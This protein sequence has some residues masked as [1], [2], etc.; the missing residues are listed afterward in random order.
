MRATRGHADRHG[1]ARVSIVQACAR[2]PYA[3]VHF[4]SSLKAWLCLLKSPFL[5]QRLMLPRIVDTLLDDD[6]RPP[7]SAPDRARKCAL[8]RRTAA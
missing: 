5:L 2:A 8:A 3:K 7:F 1:F 4:L 6:V